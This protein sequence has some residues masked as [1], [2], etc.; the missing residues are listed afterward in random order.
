MPAVP[1]PGFVVIKA[2]FDLG[3]L[4]FVFD[5]PAMAFNGSERLNVHPGRATYGEEC[6]ITVA[7]VAP[8]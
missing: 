5:G 3:R 2:E 1:G 7:N 8:D 4:N 6:E